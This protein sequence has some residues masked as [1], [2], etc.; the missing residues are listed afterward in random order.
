MSLSGTCVSGTADLMTAKVHCHFGRH[1]LSTG[2]NVGWSWDYESGYLLASTWP[3]ALE[4][5]VCILIVT[6]LFSSGVL[7]FIFLFHVFSSCVLLLD[8]RL[9]F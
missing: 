6:L 1:Q 7:E 9:G 4:C 2:L 3:G 8:F 5:C